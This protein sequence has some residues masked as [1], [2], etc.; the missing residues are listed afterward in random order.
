MPDT[1][2]LLG[3]ISILFGDEWDG[4]A[5][6]DFRS[7]ADVCAALAEHF[8]LDPEKVAQAYS[9]MERRRRAQSLDSGLPDGYMLHCPKCGSHEFA[10]YCTAIQ[11]F[12]PVRIRVRGGERV[13]DGGAAD[14]GSVDAAEAVSYGC[15]GCA[16]Q[17]DITE[18]VPSTLV[19]GREEEVMV[20][21]PAAELAL[22]R[23]R[24]RDVLA[25]TLGDDRPKPDRDTLIAV[26][27]LHTA[28][29]RILLR[30]NVPLPP[31]GA[32]DA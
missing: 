7:G 16:E 2:D 12:S 30:N 3:A 9:K 11:T 18:L 14:A 24:I 31:P 10:A 22:L 15:A 23:G 27:H 1:L 4:D 6:A 28:D 19:E 32:T 5:Y 17:L 25:V 20:T 21:I 26:G 13:E 29:A 8:D